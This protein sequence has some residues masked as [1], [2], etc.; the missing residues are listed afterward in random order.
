[1]SD[2][3]K[4]YEFTV[5]PGNE[6]YEDIERM[7]RE[8]GSFFRTIHDPVK[9]DI[10]NTILFGAVFL[11]CLIGVLTILIGAVVAGFGGVLSGLGV[12]LSSVPLAILY[13][14]RKIDS[15]LNYLISRK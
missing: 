9:D 8:K 14:A 10:L 13:Y 7:E 1:M 11:I 6:P 12:L 3:P 5:N 4:D 2:E 15:K